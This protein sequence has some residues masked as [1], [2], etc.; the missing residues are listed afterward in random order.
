[1]IRPSTFLLSLTR[2]KPYDCFDIMKFY[3]HK[4]GC[5]KNDCDADYISARLI[6][7]G[8][9]P[10]ATP[11][12]A[13]TVIVNTCGFILPA[14][15]ESIFE[16]FTLG[17]LKKEGKLR[18][19][20]ATGCLTQRYG[21][22]MKKEIPE[23]DG[24][25]GLGELDQ[26]AHAVGSD[27]LQEKIAR[28]P[29][30]QLEY[31]AG[32]KRHI[33]D[34]AP[35]AYLK[36]SDG[37]NR[38]CSF[39]AIPGIRGSY[40]SRTLESVV[41]EARFLVENGKKEL[42]LVSQESTLFGRDLKS[43]DSLMMLLEQLEKIAGLDWIRLLYLYPTQVSLDLVQHLCDPATKTLNYFDIPL[44]HISDNMLTAMN[45]QMTRTQVE[46]CLDLIRSNGGKTIRTGFIVGFPGET[47]SDFRELADFTREFGFDRMGV[48]AY[49]AEEGTS[50]FEMPDQIPEDVKNHRLDLLMTQQRT[51]VDELN[52]SLI[53]SI[54][55]VI[56]DTVLDDSS[57]V[58]RSMA[59]AP[60]I[61]QEVMIDGV[62]PEV[63]AV[64][65]VRIDRS[66]G[67]DLHGTIVER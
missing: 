67:Y 37:C 11:E 7:D 33:S 35:F 66:E 29:V 2:L 31:I 8:H 47:E 6:S 64:V 39:C 55:P 21:D 20:L 46:K 25:F 44:Q 36:I 27:K 42:I 13:E 5:P 52:N 14:K 26:L 1:M 22:E 45:R 4:L 34:S 54:Q 38:T 32:E 53:G 59:D 23:L 19:L 49:S 15:E 10:V 63:G 24:L 40:R 48:F 65:N 62:S 41:S 30:E 3:I 60:E 51:I 56:I 9:E 57:A 17:R 50:A 58:G 61:D 18:S 12:E 16:I 28:T 43:G